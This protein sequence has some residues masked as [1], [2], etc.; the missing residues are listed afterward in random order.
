MGATIY[1]K[2][3]LDRGHFIFSKPYEAGTIIIP[4]LQ[5]RN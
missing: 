1:W 3:F 4:I 2:F 5:I